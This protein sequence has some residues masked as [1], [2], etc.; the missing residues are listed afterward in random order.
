MGLTVVF[1]GTDDLHY[2]ADANSA[3]MPGLELTVSP[4]SDQLTFAEAVYP[5]PLPYT[6]PA[7]NKPINVY[8][9]DF[10]VFLPIQQTPAQSGPFEVS[11]TI[12]GIAC[13][14]QVCLAPFSYTIRIRSSFDPGTQSWTDIELTQALLGPTETHTTGPKQIAVPDIPTTDK[15]SYHIITYLLLAVVAGLSINIMPCVLPVIPLIIMRLIGKAQDSPT[16]RLRSGLAFCAGII[17]FFVVF[18]TISTLIQVT[19]DRVLNLN[20]LFRYPSAVIILF[21]AIIF[22]ALIML[23]IVVLALPGAVTSHQTNTSTLI[24][25]VGM[26][27]FAVLLS[28]P[29]SGALLGSALTLAQTQPLFVSNT[30]FILMG[31]G[32]ALPYAVIVY[33]PKLLDCIPKP[34]IWMEWFKKSCG[35]LLLFIAVKLTLVGLPKVRLINVLLYGIIFSFC[36]WIWGQWVNISTPRTRRLGIRGIALLLAVLTGF[37]LLPDPEQPAHESEGQTQQLDWQ[38]YNAIDIQK[39]RNRGQPVLIKFTADWCTNCKVLDKRVFHDPEVVGWLRDKDV[40]MVKGD[41]TFVGEKYPATAALNEVY[42]QA[43]NVP[44]TVVWTPDGTRH[45]L[46]GIFSKQALRDILR[47]LED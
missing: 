37:W 22:F 28:T 1:K 30:A 29:C 12:A 41:T 40:F 19:T 16:Q 35:F 23:D 9:G 21:L 14:R 45:D 13:T 44:F 18:A 11:V 5:S 24:G 47:R 46:P 36:I 10:E 26:G 42:G 33:I 43:G 3:P 20:G 38:D 34:G 32:M 17:L 7:L 31:V 8:V 4:S 6:D 15:T 27:L 25:S 39:A 2:Y